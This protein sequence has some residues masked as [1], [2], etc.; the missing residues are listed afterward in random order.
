MIV[1][2]KFARFP[3]IKGRLPYQVESVERACRLMRILQEQGSLPLFE[4]AR[5]ADLSRPTTFRL[6]AT[7]QANGIL[8][9]DADR[10]YRFAVGPTA[11]PRYKI[12]YAAQTS[13]YGFS[14]AV[15]RGVV[16]S[17]SKANVD[18]VLLDNQY[19]PD[20]ALVNAK[21]LLAEKID[22]LMEF[23]THSQVASLISAQASKYKVPLIAIEI[24]H[25]DATYFGVDNCQ[26]GIAAGRYLARWADQHWMGHVDEILLVGMPEAGPLP[27]ARLTGSLLGIRQ[28]L[29]NSGSSKIS[30]LNGNGQ[31]DASREVVRR[32]LDSSAAHRVLVSAINDLSA[33]GALEAFKDAGRVEDC[34]I[35]GQ[36]GSI[37]GRLEMRK[38]NSRLLGSIAYFPERYGEQLIALAF[39]ILSRRNP[40]PRAVFIKHQL[41]TPSNLKQLYGRETRVSKII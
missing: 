17:A 29:P 41:L 23:Q 22:L 20:V 3:E 13:E 10:K 25:P 5:R 27:E 11:Q 19:S 35:V 16:D 15:T 40:P 33:I 32:H 6:L 14:R 34:A 18:L 37:E 4:L 21:R 26:A 24:P 39:D 38:P 36:N 31:L 8:L 7:L 2:M 9:K 1:D 12:G 30:V 28:V